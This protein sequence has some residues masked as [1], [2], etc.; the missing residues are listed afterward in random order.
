V[1]LRF[2]G[3]SLRFRDPRRFGVLLWLDGP[4][5]AAH[6]LLVDLGIEPLTAEFD[7]AKLQA[8]FA[9]RQSPVKLVLMDAHVLVGVG[10]IYAAESLFRAGISPFRPAA[11]LSRAECERLAVAVQDTLRAA[12]AAGGSSLRDFVHSDGSSGYFQIDCAVYGR[13]GQVCRRCSGQVGQVRQA[14]RATFYCQN[15]QI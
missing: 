12:I 4:E 14:G 6:P 3:R 13:A 5:W 7:G 9:R 8:L 11:S 10:N 1:D 15:C 2:A